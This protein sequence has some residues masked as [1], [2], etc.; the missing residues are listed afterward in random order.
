MSDGFE[1][2]DV[3]EDD[4]PVDVAI[5]EPTAFAFTAFYGATPVTIRGR[6]VYAL[7]PDYDPNAGK[8]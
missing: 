6:A 2:V 5:P 7:N 4:R 3:R 8:E 1:F